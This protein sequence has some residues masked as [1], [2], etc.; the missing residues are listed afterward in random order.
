MPRLMVSL[1]R[2]PDSYKLQCSCQCNPIVIQV[3]RQAE[4]QTRQFCAISNHPMLLFNSKVILYVYKVCV[5]CIYSN[6][7]QLCVW[8]IL[9]YCFTLCMYSCVYMFCLCVMFFTLS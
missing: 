3:S 4:R 5:S 1:K 9:C 7:L 6:V 8:N 2:I